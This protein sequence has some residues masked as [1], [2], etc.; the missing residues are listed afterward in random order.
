MYIL[1]AGGGKVGYYL[2][3]ELLR[4]N[5]EVLVIERDPARV[6]LLADDLEDS[7]LEGDCCEVSTLDR[8]GIARADLVI[9][10]TGDDEDNLVTCSIARRR[11][12]GR[13]I[14]RINDPRNEV[15]FQRLGFE[16]TVSATQAILA[17]IEVEL[18][19]SDMVPLLQ[20]RSGLEIV[21]IRLPINS[22]AA[23]RAIKNVMLPSES[24]ITLVVDPGGAPR[25][26]TGDTVLNAGD[27]LV[28]VTR[29]D[30]V[31]TLK[32]AL[33]GATHGLD[34]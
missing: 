30:G 12:A 21:E 31:E 19:T 8:A 14:A 7:L 5:H 33:V 2:A 9:A 34:T 18:P 4:A 29:K 16:T 27:A 13:M 6:K 1:I 20:L 22:P 23:G 3:E 25:I 24:L 11:G 17:Q 15:L 28:L 10:V 26:P 32:E